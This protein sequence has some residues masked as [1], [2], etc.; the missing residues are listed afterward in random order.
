MCK[1]IEFYL[2]ISIDFGV[3]SVFG[4]CFHHI[5]GIPL[6]MATS[7]LC[8]I[9]EYWECAF[10]VVCTNVCR[11]HVFVN[12]HYLNFDFLWKSTRNRSIHKLLW[13]I[14]TNE[15]WRVAFINVIF[16]IL[17]WSIC[18]RMSNTHQ[19]ASVS[20]RDKHSNIHTHMYSRWLC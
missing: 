7:Y 20:N 3:L 1:T 4:N 17:M 15:A 9:V 16:D 12:S 5:D 13:P 11:F 8:R 14:H 10:V 2:F 18:E 6:A 19:K